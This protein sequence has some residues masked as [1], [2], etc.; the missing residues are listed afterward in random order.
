MGRKDFVA[1]FEETL[2]REPVLDRIRESRIHWLMAQNYR[3][4]ASLHVRCVD[5]RSLR[6]TDCAFNRDAYQATGLDA[7]LLPFRKGALRDL[8]FQR[9]S[10]CDR[11]F[12][13]RH[14]CSRLANPTSLG[15]CR[16]D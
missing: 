15:D 2:D 6:G 7:A 8:Q 12:L 13:S 4:G 9:R 3:S 10:L 5:Q 16:R 1:R 14:K 11:S